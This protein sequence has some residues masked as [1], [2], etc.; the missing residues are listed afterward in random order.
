MS[1]YLTGITL[2]ILIS[3]LWLLV[4][5][6]WLRQFPQAG[7]PDALAHRSGC[8]NCACDADKRCELNAKE[9]ETEEP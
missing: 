8:H 1:N 3:G 6:L 5:R 4:Q 7:D 9:T 2:L